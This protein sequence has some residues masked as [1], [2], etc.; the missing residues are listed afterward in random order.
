M[1][2]PKK[3]HFAN[4]CKADAVSDRY[5]SIPFNCSDELGQALA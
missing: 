5:L 3:G 1:D 4:L 2:F